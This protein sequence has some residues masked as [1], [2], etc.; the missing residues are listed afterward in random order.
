M[1][2]PLL[3]AEKEYMEFIINNCDY[4]YDEINFWQSSLVK[5]K[6]IKKKKKKKR[7]NKENIYI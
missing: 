4:D 5:K 1:S 2:E 3:T 7:K 6:K